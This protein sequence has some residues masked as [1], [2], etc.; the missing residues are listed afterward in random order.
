V[1]FSKDTGNDPDARTGNPNPRA[2]DLPVNSLQVYF[3]YRNPFC[4]AEATG[5]GNFT[6]I[7]S[8][9]IPE[10]DHLHSI[11]SSF[12][13]G[14]FSFMK[15]KKTMKSESLKKCCRNVTGHFNI[16]NE[17]ADCKAD[18]GPTFRNHFT[19]MVTFRWIV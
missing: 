12:G 5:T 11:I 19:G 6:A 9:P 13:T 7:V 3:C 4:I 18:I 10:Q 1:K 8:L 17:V 16:N 15:S 14:H 2:L